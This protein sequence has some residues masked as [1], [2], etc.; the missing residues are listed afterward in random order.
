ML[1][2]RIDNVLIYDGL[3][4]APLHGSV[5]IKGNRIVAVG[6]VGERA[7]SETDCNGLAIMPGIIDNHTHYD[8]QITWDRLANPSL[9]LGVTTIV[10]GNCGFTI[11]PCRASDRDLTIR[12]LTHV[13]GM[14]LDSLR[15]GINWEF[16]SFPQY[17]DLLEHRG[18][19][20]NVAVFCGHSSIRTF[21]MGAEASKRKATKEEIDKM[22]SILLEALQSGACGFSTTRSGQ[23]NG[24]AGVP[25]PSRLSCFEELSSLSEVLR[26]VGHGVSMMTKGGDTTIADIEKLARVSGRPFV[27]AALLHSPLAPEKTFDDLNQISKANSRGVELYGAVSPCPLTMEFT[28][29]DPYTFEGLAVWGPLMKMNKND[30]I[31]VISDSEFRD[32][33]R[34]ELAITDYRIFNGDWDKVFVTQV[35]DKQNRHL[36]GQSLSEIGKDK[37]TDPLD[38]MFDLSLSE[39]L[40]TLF[41]ATLLNSDEQAVGRM[42]NHDKSLISL[43]DAGAHL[44]FFCDAGYGLH[45]LGHWARDLGVLSMSEAVKKLT[46]EPAKLFGI[47]HRGIIK[48]GYFAD[49][50]LFDPDTVG[51]GEIR[52]IND[53]P[54]GGS[55]LTTDSIGV[56][57]VWVNGQMVVNAGG[58]LPETPHAGSLL[59]NFT[60]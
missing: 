50:L 40:G 53:L 27:I 34:A 46:Y 33:M 58:Y 41:T 24:E 54:A 29:H 36:E 9:L 59:R 3:A 52:R 31:K 38:V 57:G 43:S 21:V 19:G 2:V 25:M 7:I 45:L 20:L 1:D 22:Q 10:M 60:S 13:E 37:G 23:H 18:L 15:V 6:K 35:R 8:A 55:R 51:R 26:K 32:K 49:L 48:S 14:P 5:G 16:E 56:L 44:T 11:A 17:M 39:D 30:M 4:S 42:I 28:M 12:N 47:P